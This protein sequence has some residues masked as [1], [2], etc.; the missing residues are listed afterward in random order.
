[1]T[2]LRP[3]RH[4][5]GITSPRATSHDSRWPPPGHQGSD[6]V[7]TRR[8]ASWKLP[9]RLHPKCRHR[10]PSPPGA[11]TSPHALGV[12]AAQRIENDP[13]AHGTD[14]GHF[15]HRRA[16]AGRTDVERRKLPASSVL[17][18]Q[19]PLRGAALAFPS[20]PSWDSGVVRYSGDDQPIPIRSQR[21]SRIYW[22]RSRRCA[23]P[24]VTI[25]R[26]SIHSSI[27]CADHP[28]ARDPSRIAAGKSSACIRR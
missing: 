1:M 22:R 9:V 16:G 10:F 26:E 21:G 2:G 20:Q 5:H 4:P 11:S 7:Q 8:T 17:L 18:A 24:P 15:A 25:S 27:R 19:G 28:T 23:A 14:F 12:P 6:D 13:E 3:G